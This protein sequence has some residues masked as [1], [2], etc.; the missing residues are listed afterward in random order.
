MKIAIVHDFLNQFGGA[1]RVV[2]AL[3]EIYP[4]APIYTSIY[5]E[6]RMPKSF[7]S[8]DIRVS[9]M[10]KLPFV[11]KLYR[12]YVLLYPL[13][14]S[15]FD[16]SGYDVI[17]SSSSSFAKGIKKREGQLHICYCHN[18]MRF[19]W[20]YQDYIKGE[21]IPK[22]IKWLLPYLLY[23]VR[24]WDLKTAESVDYF[25][26]NSRNVAQR[27]NQIYE[28]ESDIINPPVETKIFKPSAV[29]REYFLVLSR[30]NP[31]KRVDIAVRAFNKLGL[32]LKIIGMGPDQWK[33]RQLAVPNIEFIGKRLD[34]ELGKYLA[35]CR[36]LIFPGEEDF[37][38][39]PLEAMASGR[40]VIAYEAGGALETVVEGETGL[41]FKPQTPEALMLA[42]RKFTK[43]KFDKE[44]IRRQA[45][46]FDKE[47]FKSKVKEF[48]E[49]KWR[50]KANLK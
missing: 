18:P 27:I 25:I 37:G 49:E 5:D 23:P 12:A 39:V 11:F 28:R 26:A 31:Y 4:H 14:F 36:A 50:E 34:R 22:F 17:L 19:V 48:I 16:L 24:Q 20:R 13:A 46:K 41:F 15:R 47:I 32:P 1:E 10:Q 6:K 3:H 38:I 35:E 43:K 7:H 2:E 33:L 40:P 42:V 45:E 30:L 9:F 8:M 44:N 29:D 21:A